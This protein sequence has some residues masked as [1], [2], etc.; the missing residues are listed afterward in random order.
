M[1]TLTRVLVIDDNPRMVALMKR[2]LVRAGYHVTGVTNVQDALE[3][4]TANSIDWVIT[5]L[6][7]PT[8]DGLD[9]LAYARS[10]HPQAKVIVMTAFGSDATR[11][12]AFDHGAYAFLSKPFS[13]DALLAI[14]PPVT[15]SDHD[16]PV[17]GGG[18]PPP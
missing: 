10:H 12:R 4:L 13:G 2:W 3:A 9:V 6:M 14:L 15:P 8:G 17:A 18:Q 5:D 16:R 1:P 7:M 11:Q